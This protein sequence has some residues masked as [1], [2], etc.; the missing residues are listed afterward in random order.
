MSFLVLP[1]KPPRVFLDLG[2]LVVMGFGVGVVLGPF[3][4]L[5]AGTPLPLEGD[6]SRDEWSFGARTTSVGYLAG[7]VLAGLA[8][9][10]IRRHHDLHKSVGAHARTRDWLVYGGV[11]TASAALLPI[12]FLQLLISSMPGP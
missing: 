9:F 5:F 1:V 6:F 2:V 8:W 12:L 3:F 11:M 4:H 10:S 7:T